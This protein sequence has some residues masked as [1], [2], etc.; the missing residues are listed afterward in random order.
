MQSRRNYDTLSGRSCVLE[1]RA[2]NKAE[3]SDGTYYGYHDDTNDET[4]NQAGGI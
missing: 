1:K 2:N 4:A 3:L